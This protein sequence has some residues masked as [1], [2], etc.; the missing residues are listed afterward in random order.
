MSHFIG[1]VT[2]KALIYNNGKILLSRDIDDEMFD[3]PGGR[4]DFDEVPIEGLKRELVEELGITVEILSQIYTCQTVWGS[5]L[6]PHFFIA[7]EATCI[8]D[9]AEMKA[10]G[11]EVAEFGWF[12]QSEIYH[13]PLYKECIAAI[14]AL[15][16][17]K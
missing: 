13:I 1:K 14:E 3:L 8:S 6:S 9:L 10:D 11:I 12:T 7:Y 4:L 16:L 15:L 2:Q 17:N 5:D